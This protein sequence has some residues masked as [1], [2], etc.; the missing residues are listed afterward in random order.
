MSQSGTYEF[1]TTQSIFSF[2]GKRQCLVLIYCKVNKTRVKMEV[3][4]SPL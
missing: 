2:T 1:E 3:P 4:L